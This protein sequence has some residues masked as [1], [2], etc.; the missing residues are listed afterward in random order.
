MDTPS[1]IGL[2][3]IGLFSPRVILWLIQD[4]KK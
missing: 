4:F 3:L 1:W 2:A